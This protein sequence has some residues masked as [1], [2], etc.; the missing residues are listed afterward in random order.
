MS[1]W[2]FIPGVWAPP[3]SGAENGRNWP[4]SFW[5]VPETQRNPVRKMMQM[6]RTWVY[7]VDSIDRT[8][9]TSSNQNVE[10][11][12]FTVLL[13][14]LL[15]GFDGLSTH[16]GWQIEH[17]SRMPK[18]GDSA[19]H[20]QAAASCRSAMSRISSSVPQLPLWPS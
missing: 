15:D 12:H 6:S 2:C 16:H 8:H 1:M 14:G 9:R 19:E 11:F 5:V 18:S 4:K 20:V 13:W 7:T 17:A 3:V 10:S